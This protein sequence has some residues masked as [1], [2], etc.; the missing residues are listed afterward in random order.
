MQYVV[1]RNKNIKRTKNATIA[2]HTHVMRN[3][4]KNWHGNLT[5]DTPLEQRLQPRPRASAGVPPRLWQPLL[6]R[7]CPGVTETGRRM[8]N[9]NLKVRDGLSN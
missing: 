2:K 3:T 4:N 1:L 9:M 5:L 6:L 7:P 8:L